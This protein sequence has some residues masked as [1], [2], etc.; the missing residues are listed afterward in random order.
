MADHYTQFSEIIED[1][2]PEQAEWIETV[3]GFDP[4]DPKFGAEDTALAALGDLLGLN[5]EEMKERDIEWWPGF[6]W[7][8]R[9]ADNGS[10]WLHCDEG[11]QENCLIAFVQSYIRK[12]RPD[13]IFRV[14]M[15]HS[16][17]KPRAGEFGGGWLAISKDKVRGG[18][19]WDAS[20]EAVKEM[21]DGKPQGPT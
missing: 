15:A 2:T 1:V 8:T 11:F 7:S 12:F 20:E 19:T 9:G 3:L 4:D 16:C 21:M 10:L 14:S 18:N 6:E 17:S 5:L 13:Y